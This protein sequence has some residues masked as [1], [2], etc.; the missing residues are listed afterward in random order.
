M[1]EWTDKYNP[2]NS[3]KALVHADR[4]ESILE[5]KVQPPL[6]VNM[7]LTNKCNYGCRFCMFGGIERA[8]PSGQGYRFNQAELPK[9]YAPKLPKVWKDWGVKAVCLAGGGEPSLHEDCMP[10]IRQCG[11]EEL[12]LGFVTN[13]YLVDDSEWHECLVGNARF[14]GFSVDAGTPDA[15]T[16]T[17]G[18]HHDHFWRVIE[19]ISRLS[20]M[21][22]V[23][24][25]DMQ[26]GYKFLL[27]RMN[28]DTVYQA[29]QIASEIGVNHFQFRPAIDHEYEFFEGKTEQIWAQIDHAQEDFTRD[30]FHVYGVKHKF[31]EDLSKKHEFGQCRANMLTTTWAADG[32]VYMC[33]DTRGNPWSKLVDHYPDPQRVIDYW[34]SK[35]HW[36]R[37]GEIDHMNNCDRCT[38]TAYNE[39]F[40]NVFMEDKMDRNLI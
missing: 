22:D 4:F 25:S 37:V 27:D 15:Y 3:W 21:R 30:D 10:F 32:N 19:N 34:G 2:F 40:E 38:L 1:S 6:V 20:L 26:I 14:T 33:T 28:W 9:G 29:A 24:D 31:N 36:G 35:D 7:D 23:L 39:M 13:G 5:G 8:D 12:E 17:K 11:N 18:V 16:R